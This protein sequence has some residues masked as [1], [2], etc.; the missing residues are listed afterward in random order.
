MKHEKLS[1]SLGVRGKRVFALIFLLIY[2]AVCLLSVTAKLL[3]HAEEECIQRL[4]DA[5]LEYS[6]NYYVHAMSDREQLRVVADMLSALM[7]EGT[8]DLH[9]H[10]AAFEQR[11]MLDW[12][13]VLMPNGEL[14]TGSGTFDVNGKLDY[15]T[16]V[17]RLPYIS[18]VS[19][20]LVIPEKR[21]IRSAVPVLKDGETIA[22]LYGVYDLTIGH[23]PGGVTAYNGEAYTFVIESDTNNYIRDGL[24]GQHTSGSTESAYTAKPGFD[25]SLMEED[26]AAC[27]EGYSAFASLSVDEY[28]YIY[29]VP[30]G[31]NNWMVMVSVPESAALDFAFDSRHLLMGTLGY[32]SLGVILYFLYLYRLDKTLNEKNQFISDIQSQL[33]DVYHKPDHFTDAMLSVANRARGE[34]LLL[35]DEHLPEPFSIHGEHV[36]LATAYQKHAAE[37]NDE[38]LALCR[39]HRKP[40]RL[41]LR[42]KILRTYPHLTQLLQQNGQRS[43]ALMPLLTAEGDIHQVMA[44]FSPENNNVLLLMDVLAPDFFIAANNI[45]FLTRLNIASTIDNLTKTR[46]R[47]SYHL[48]LESLCNATPQNFAC[49]YVDVNDLHAINNRFGHDQGD[50]MLRTIAAALMDACGRENVYRFGGDE[51]IILAENVASDWIENALRRAEVTINQ[52]GYTVSIGWDWA[53]QTTNV[54]S[55]IRTAESRMYDNKYLFYQQKEKSHAKR[56]AKEQSLQR[57]LTGNPDIDAFLHVAGDHYR[58]VYIVN[59]LTDAVREIIAHSYFHMALE[60]NDQKFSKA[61]RHYMA[62]NVDKQSRRSIQNFFDYKQINAQVAAGETPIVEYSKIDGERV[63]LTVHRLPTYTPETP[64]TLWII[65]VT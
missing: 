51:F 62:E 58:G 50:A 25:L 11:G 52:A 45:D 19:N 39:Q 32:L 12:L 65:E 36:A 18:N 55:M 47:T 48:R 64:E 28:R 27:R 7:E 10:L 34:A 57:L 53:E 49:A 29:Y 26:L 20:G 2:I 17:T 31:I 38:L 16:E 59:I 9:T 23:D 63:R 13:Q 35:L 44:I 5:T 15:E 56:Q 37:L 6:N 14:L 21:V 33:M 22:V 54:D 4:K 41:R 46:N 42:S 3:D 30:V 24:L 61:F 40:M 8:H 1:I 43:L 60:E